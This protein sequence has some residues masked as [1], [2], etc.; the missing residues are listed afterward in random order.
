MTADSLSFNDSRLGHGGYED[1][2]ISDKEYALLDV[3]VV[4]DRPMESREI[5]SLVPSVLSLGNFYVVASQLEEKGLVR[6]HLPS[7]S[8]P[9]SQ[10][11]PRHAWSI[12]T[13]GRQAHLKA[14]HERGGQM[15]SGSV[16]TWLLNYFTL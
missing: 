16:L 1:P 12:N 8:V 5:V 14:S 10:R 3:L 15:P 2:V 4:N 9:A 11:Q 7:P 6:E 13:M